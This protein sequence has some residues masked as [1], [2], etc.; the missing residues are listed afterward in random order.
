[1]SERRCVEVGCQQIQGCS[2]PLLSFAHDSIPCWS[3]SAIMDDA[4]SGQ[5]LAI[6]SV[7]QAKWLVALASGLATS[8]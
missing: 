3:L 2:L 4:A 5:Q 7:G 6:L 8:P 1:M